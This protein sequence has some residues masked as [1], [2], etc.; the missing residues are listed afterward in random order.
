MKVGGII[1]IGMLNLNLKTLVILPIVFMWLSVPVRAQADACGAEGVSLDHVIWAVPDLED[2]VARFEA[3]TSIKPKYGGEHTN[4]VTANY[5]VSLGP[6][7]YL[8]IVGP[9]PGVT[10][11]ML[12]ERAKTYAREHVAGFALGADLDNPPETLG[13]V[14]LGNRSEGGRSKPDGTS[15][16]WVTAPLIDFDFG[17]DKF[18]FV[19][20]W[21]SKP[22]PAATAAE[23]AEIMH[24]TIADPQVTGLRTI[25]ESN[26]LPIVLQP[27]GVPNIWLTIRTPKGSVT[28]RGKKSQR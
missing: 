6:C 19:I 20:K 2:Y 9:K 11:E 13:T 15:L 28:L 16:S 21:T 27:S 8:E 26:R 25:V 12:G 7:T 18:Q 14:A 1:C 5:L 24:L 3:L 17:D 10:P 22:H 4:G 23:G